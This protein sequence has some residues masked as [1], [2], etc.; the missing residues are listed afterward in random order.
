MLFAWVVEPDPDEALALA[1]AEASA[2]ALADPEPELDVEVDVDVDVDVDTE[3][4]VLGV[5]VFVL[6]FVQAV[7]LT[8]SAWPYL[9]PRRTYPSAQ[10]TFTPSVGFTQLTLSPIH[11]NTWPFGQATFLFAPMLLGGNI[12]PA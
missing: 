5:V 9:M 2:D 6:V 1:E 7:I 8:Q 11:F 3:T 12:V 10:A 4:E